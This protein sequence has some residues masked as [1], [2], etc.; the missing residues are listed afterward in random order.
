[1]PQ[2]SYIGRRVLAH[3][4]VWAPNEKAHIKAEGGPEVSVRAYDVTALEVRLGDDTAT[5]AMSLGE[6]AAVLAEL[7]TQGCCEETPEG[8]RMTQQGFA[9]LTDPTEPEGQAREVGSAFVDLH[10]AE[11]Q[12]EGVGV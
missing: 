8:W 11:V 9:V 10:P 3:L 1:M 7:M 12:S 2:L 6:L 5:P 4:P